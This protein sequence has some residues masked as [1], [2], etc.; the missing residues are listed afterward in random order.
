MYIMYFLFCSVVTY[1]AYAASVEM[2]DRFAA[3]R[4]VVTGFIIVPIAFPL[5]ALLFFINVFR[6]QGG[7]RYV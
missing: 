1:Y 2:K 4:A 3:L 7:R 5:I 6:T